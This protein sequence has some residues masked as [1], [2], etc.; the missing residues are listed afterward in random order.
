MTLIPAAMFAQVPP[1]IATSSDPTPWAVGWGTL[2][3]I[4]A[5]LAESKGRSRF[6]WFLYSLLLGPIATFLI[7]IL[8]KKPPKQG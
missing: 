5:A 2:M 8:D 7:V 6:N 1:M 3:L 4:N